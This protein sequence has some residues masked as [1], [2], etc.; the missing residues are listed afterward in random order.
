MSLSFRRK[1]PK[2]KPQYVAFIVLCKG[3]PMYGMHV[4]YKTFLK[5]YVVEPRFKKR[6][7][8]CLRAGAIMSTA[9]DV[10]ED[11]IPFPMQFMLDANLYGCGW[12]EVAKCR[13]RQPLPGAY[14]STTRE[15]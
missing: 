9:F 1:D 11:H 10:Y 3:T 12:V 5:I 14:L 4:G 15:E 8:E 13:F 2:S 6:M 7:S